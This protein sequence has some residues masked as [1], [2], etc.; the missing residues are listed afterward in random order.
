[1]GYLA[2]KRKQTQTDA[3]QDAAI[4]NILTQG[5]GAPS[6]APTAKNLLYFNTTSSKL[7]VSTGTTASSDWTEV[8][9]A[10]PA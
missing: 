9:A 7:Y 1:M 4:E 5:A 3:A 10:D 6:K 8:K 2:D